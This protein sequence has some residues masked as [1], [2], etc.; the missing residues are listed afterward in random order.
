MNSRTKIENQLIQEI[1]TLP[2]E[3]LQTMLHL[4]N[5]VKKISPTTDSSINVALNDFLKRYEENPI[6]IDTEIFEGYRKIA[7]DRDFKL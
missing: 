5:S 4:V 6:D 1:H 3:I 2:L 7:T